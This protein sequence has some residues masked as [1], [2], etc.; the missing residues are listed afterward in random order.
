MC[1][2]LGHSNKIVLCI[3]GE[4]NSILP[5]RKDTKNGGILSWQHAVY[6]NALITMIL[7]MLHPTDFSESFNQKMRTLFPPPDKFGI[8]TKKRYLYG[9]FPQVNTANRLIQQLLWHAS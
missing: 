9:D 1:G 5:V 2:F 4:R 8:Q 7:I 3:A 6:R